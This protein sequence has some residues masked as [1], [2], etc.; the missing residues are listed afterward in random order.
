MPK[1]NGMIVA[2][3]STPLTPLGHAAASRIDHISGLGAFLA[4]LV[5][6]QGQSSRVE[7]SVPLDRYIILDVRFD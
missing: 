4:N 5:T 3:P 6:D 2:S 7:V 1:G